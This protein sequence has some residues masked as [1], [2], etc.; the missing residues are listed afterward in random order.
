MRF[1]SFLESTSIC[2]QVR[3][4]PYEWNGKNVM[5]DNGYYYIA[6]NNPND[7]TYLTVWTEDNKRIGY[8]ATQTVTKKGVPWLKVDNVDIKK[9]H[10]GSKLGRTLYQILVWNMNPE[11][12]GLIGY[13]PDIVNK[14]VHSIYKRLGA[15]DDGGDNWF[16][17]NPNAK[18]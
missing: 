1:I 5:W 11:R 7:P 15:E 14:R 4:Q 10:Q 17:R 3:A 16:V 13:K 9:S 18:V 6:A 2:E 12:G 8:M